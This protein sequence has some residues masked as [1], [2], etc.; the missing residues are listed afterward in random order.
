MQG[1]RTIT[2][3]RISAI[4]WHTM[5]DGSITGLI[6][7]EI[8]TPAGKEHAPKYYIGSVKEPT[9]PHD[10]AVKIINNGRKF[11]KAWLEE[12]TKKGTK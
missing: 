4:G 1:G 11:P 3:R 5:P 8:T 6:K 9:T 2:R 7:V 12:L 10:D